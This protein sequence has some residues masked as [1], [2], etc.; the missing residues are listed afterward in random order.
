MIYLA[1]LPPGELSTIDRLVAAYGFSRNHL[2]KIILKLGKAGL[3]EAVRGKN[4][5]IRLGRPADT[6]LL[7]DILRALE[8]LQVVNCQISYCHLTPACTLKNIFV[9]AT[10]AFVA[11][12]DKYH[13][14][15]LTENKAQL[16][17][18][19]GIK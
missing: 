17:P 13:L 5:G 4:G 11:E 9:D 3:V 12:L 1:L 14:S 6:I 7:G 15:D 19:L 2:I 16:K 18:L 8:P 10:R